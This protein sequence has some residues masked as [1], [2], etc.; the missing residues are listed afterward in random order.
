MLLFKRHLIFSLLSLTALLSGYVPLSHALEPGTC[1]TREQPQTLVEN[2]LAKLDWQADGQLVLKLKEDYGNEILWQPETYNAA[3]SLCLLEDGNLVISAEEINFVEPTPINLKPG[4]CLSGGQ[5]L[6]E[7]GIVSLVWQGDGNLVLYQ[8][9]NKKIKKD[10]AVWATNTWHQNEKMRQKKL[11][12]QEGE[13]IVY[14]GKQEKLW[15][16]ATQKKGRHLELGPNCNLRLLDA[17]KR[18]LWQSRKFGAIRETETCNLKNNTVWRAIKTPLDK[19]SKGE[20]F[21]ETTHQL[22]LSRCTLYLNEGENRLALTT[23]NDCI[24]ETRNEYWALDQTSN[25]KL[26]YAL[27][28]EKHKVTGTE[29]HSEDKPY[30]SSPYFT[31]YI[32]LF[33]RARFSKKY[34]TLINRSASDLDTRG[35]LGN[36]ISSIEYRGIWELCKDPEFNG[37]CI[38][39]KSKNVARIAN[40]SNELGEDW[41]DAISSVKLLGYIDQQSEYLIRARF[42]ETRRIC[43]ST[44][45]VG[46]YRFQLLGADHR[47]FTNSGGLHSECVID[48]SKPGATQCCNTAYDGTDQPRYLSW[49]KEQGTASEAKLLSLKVTLDE[50]LQQGKLADDAMQDMELDEV[51]AKAPE[52]QICINRAS[53]RCLTD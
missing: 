25:S 46:R 18:P 5:T 17:Q 8:R 9:P 49:Q 44:S 52:A 26:Y 34:V 36:A 2:H 31:P 41:N 13:L 37:E 15:T 48:F 14:Q 42:A 4:Q 20:Y 47:L 3:R 33:D 50:K 22:T 10:R 32:R 1:L 51:L 16:T 27:T 21:P 11:C 35:L 38:Q 40:I 45:G 12:F 24:P 19:A 43:A 28:R 7:N 29:T 23:T 39:L 6:A 53:A 30:K